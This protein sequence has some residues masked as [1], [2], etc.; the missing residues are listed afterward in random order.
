MQASYAGQYEALWRHHW[1]WQ[2]RHQ[3]VLDALAELA[4]RR[5]AG[6][7]LPLLL[8]IGCGGGWA[9]DD[10]SRFCEV[11]GLEPN[12][13]LADV[14]PRWRSRIERRPFGPHYAG[15]RA[16]DVVLMLDVL[17][18]LADDKG[19][20]ANL[21]HLLKP[22]GRL[23]LTVPALPMLWSV[24][25]EVNQHFRRY[26]WRGLRRALVGQGFEI[27]EM[28]YLFGWSLG[29]LLAR[30][31]LSNPKAAYQVRIPPVWINAPLRWLSRFEEFV[32][33]I[34]G[35]GPLLGSSLL[36][37]AR[38]PAT[39]ASAYPTEARRRAA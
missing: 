13:E 18:H 16:Y 20:L 23:L 37:V 9:F 1:W 31:W 19:A 33:R 2:A 17:E 15:A 26:T 39:A 4:P 36:A 8:D 29:L 11:Y 14:L 21:H 30:R 10:F 32:G 7:A 34:F 5:R 24:H 27:E 3:V 25:D 38:R 22:G 35:G 6:A 12:Q 28:R